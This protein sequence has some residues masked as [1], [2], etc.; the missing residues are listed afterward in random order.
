MLLFFYFFFEFSLLHVISFAQNAL[1][2]ISVLSLW[3]VFHFLIFSL[4]HPSLLFSDLSKKWTYFRFTWWYLED[5]TFL[6]IYATTECIGILC[7]FNMAGL[8]KSWISLSFP[9]RSRSRLFVKWKFLQMPLV[10]FNQS[11]WIIS[12]L[13]KIMY[14]ISNKRST[15][16]FW[17]FKNG[18]LNMQN[19]LILLQH[20]FLWH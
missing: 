14:F 2:F 13:I 10:P 17:Q 1:F 11:F 9:T 3:W 18:N 16:S 5:M 7:L 6:M 8:H 15:P 4:S 20:D 12:A 19:S